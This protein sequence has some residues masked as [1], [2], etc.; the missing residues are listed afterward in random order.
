MFRVHFREFDTT[1]EVG[2]ID[3]STYM[4]VTVV[5]SIQEDHRAPVESSA[6]VGIATRHGRRTYELI[7]ESWQ[8]H[9]VLAK[10]IVDYVRDSER[11][12][13]TIVADGDRASRE[14]TI[15]LELDAPLTA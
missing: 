7:D 11:S 10:A 14:K 6:T 5:F 15:D 2:G 8:R 4:V 1:S 3:G 13:R 12:L 9:P